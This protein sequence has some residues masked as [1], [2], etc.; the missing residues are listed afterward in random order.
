MRVGSLL[1]PSMPVQE[2]GPQLPFRVS[3][4]KINKTERESHVTAVQVIS[5]YIYTL[6]FIELVKIQ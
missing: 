5:A 2:T 3:S 6:I 1:E 4:S